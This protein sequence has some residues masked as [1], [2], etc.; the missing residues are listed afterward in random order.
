[1][2]VNQHWSQFFTP[3]GREYF[4]NSLTNESSWTRPIDF[5]APP[6]PKREFCIA[7]KQLDETWAIMITNKNHELFYNYQTKQ[8][9]WDIPQEIL[10]LVHRLLGGT[11]EESESESDPNSVADSIN[12]D[13]ELSRPDQIL[14]EPFEVENKVSHPIVEIIRKP[15]KIDIDKENSDFLVL[16]NE[17]ANPMSTWS[18]E[19]PLLESDPRF[20]KTKRGKQLFLSWCERKAAELDSQGV[21]NE[22]AF[23]KLLNEKVLKVMRFD[24]F[25]HLN[26][27]ALSRILLSEKDKI[28]LFNKH[29]GE[30]QEQLK[31]RHNR[32]FVELLKEK[33]IDKSYNWLRTRLLIESE[34]RYLAVPTL[35]EKENLFR[36]YISKL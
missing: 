16:L 35:L 28:L 17:K 23:Q 5:M 1:M 7:K 10:G 29:V 21:E 3:D 33:G 2:S 13:E 8:S 6:P 25:N 14:M 20:I 34:P 9:F 27:L 22:R 11:V 26:T 32:E 36:K 18:L 15:Q 30:L 4:F 31:K 24:E 12:I 19:S